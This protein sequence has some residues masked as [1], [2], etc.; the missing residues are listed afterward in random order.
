M[1]DEPLELSCPA[2]RA[3]YERVVLAHGGGGRVMQRLIAD[4]F[5]AAFEGRELRAQHDGAVLETSARTA[6]TTDA[7][8][9]RPLVFPGGDIGSLAVHGTV[10]DLAAC[11]ARPRWMTAAFVLEEGLELA[12]L[13]RLVASMASAARA[14]GV[15][16]VAGDTK[17]VEHGRGDGVYIATTGV[18]EVIAPRP[19]LPA[20]VRAGDAILVSGPVGDHGTAVMLAREGIGIEAAIESDAASVWPA[21]EALLEARVAVH[22]LRDPTR[23]GLAAALAEIATGA[24][25]GMSIVEAAIPVRPEVADACELMGLDPLYVACEGRLVVIVPERDAVRARHVLRAT[26][27]G[28]DAQRIGSVVDAHRGVVTLVGETGGE[29]VLD[30]LSGEQLPRIC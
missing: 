7:F 6:V 21:V 9:V 19:I 13:R 26:A 16:V 29:R 24:Q 8:T 30:L 14:A 3:G 17:V 11:G 4:V 15:T 23:G 2:P 12:V 5:V 25:V 22:C 10:N 18:G 28:R 27:I 20:R 1:K